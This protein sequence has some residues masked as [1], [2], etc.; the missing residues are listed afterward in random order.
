VTEEVEK[1]N[2]RD[3]SLPSLLKLVAENS[4]FLAEQQLKQLLGSH[5]DEEK[6]LIQMDRVFIVSNRLQCQFYFAF[7]FKP[8]VYKTLKVITKIPY[9]NSRIYCYAE[10]PLIRINNA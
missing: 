6:M 2:A 4:D 9:C 5:I 7:A 1:L 8:L 10:L 3:R